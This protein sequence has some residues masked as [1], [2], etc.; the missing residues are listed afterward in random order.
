M[1]TI[2]LSLFLALACFSLGGCLTAPVGKS[3]GPGAITVQNT[4]PMAILNAARPI[5]AESGY[6]GGPGNFP[7]SISFQKP[8]GRLGKVMYGSFDNSPAIRVTISMIQLPGTNDYRLVPHVARVNN[9]GEAGFEDTSRMLQLW[10]GEFKPLLRK[11]AEQA[12]AAG[13]GY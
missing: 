6:S 1:K 9:P 12:G 8:T 2:P 13:P 5:F 11:V 3:G 4:N 7:D 10:S